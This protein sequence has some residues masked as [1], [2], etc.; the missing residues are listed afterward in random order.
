MK[1]WEEKEYKWY[2][3]AAAA[4]KCVRNTITKQNIMKRSR[5]GKGEK[6]HYEE[7]L[8]RVGDVG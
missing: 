6:V 1:K 8:T 4:R 7:T 5:S 2:I 3:W